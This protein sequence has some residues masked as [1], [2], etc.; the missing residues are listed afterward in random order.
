MNRGEY[1]RSKLDGNLRGSCVV[2]VY[3]NMCDVT[4][5]EFNNIKK[6][7]EFAEKKCQNNIF[8]NGRRIFWKRVNSKIV[9]YIDGNTM[10]FII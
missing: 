5:K 2:M 7:I 4:I 9:Y 3:N 10:Q 6:A 1:M 8:F